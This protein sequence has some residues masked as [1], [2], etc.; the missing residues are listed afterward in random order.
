MKLAGREVRIKRETLAERAPY[1]PTPAY[2]LPAMKTASADAVIATTKTSMGTASV[3]STNIESAQVVS[4]VTAA[5][6]STGALFVTIFG[7]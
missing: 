5:G 7:H 2:V 3:V 4:I 6:M 1:V